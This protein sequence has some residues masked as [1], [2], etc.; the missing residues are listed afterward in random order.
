MVLC[1]LPGRVCPRA[2]PASK[3]RLLDGF[4]ETELYRWKQFRIVLP[5][6]SRR[7][8]RDFDH[9]GLHH[10]VGQMKPCQGAMSLPGIVVCLRDFIESE[11]FSSPF[12]A[13][14][15]LLSRWVQKSLKL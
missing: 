10:R 13:L 11:N 5:S 4:D 1:L 2:D 12:V 14:K 9:S 15:S 3:S 8:P 6:T 7:P